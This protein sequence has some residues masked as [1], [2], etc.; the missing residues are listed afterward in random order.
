VYVSSTCNIDQTKGVTLS[1]K[2]QTLELE[3]Y[4]GTSTTKEHRLWV[5]G[6]FNGGS[7]GLFGPFFQPTKA[8]EALTKIIE[9]TQT[10]SAVIM[11]EYK[12]GESK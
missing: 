8:Q 9:S 1:K 3:E 4:W 6:T 2:V 5:V 10:T 12:Q 7:P 11:I